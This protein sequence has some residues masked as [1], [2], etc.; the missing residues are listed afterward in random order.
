MNQSKIALTDQLRQLGVWEDAALW[1]D[2]RK[3][4]LVDEGMTRRAA[5]ERAWGETEDQFSGINLDRFLALQTALMADYAPLIA[6]SIADAEGEPSFALVWKLWCLCS[7]RLDCWELNEF[8]NAAAITHQ[9]TQATSNS[10][11]A[12]R[13]MAA[14][15]VN[16]FGAQLR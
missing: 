13:S 3:R 2:Q 10:E 16:H 11:A 9:L 14:L 7:A 1:K 5:R 12:L 8:E 4:E 6:P 15:T